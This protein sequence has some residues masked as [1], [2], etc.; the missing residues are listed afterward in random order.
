[1]GLSA[2]LLYR[3]RRLS[4]RGCPNPITLSGEMTRLLTSSTDDWATM[5]GATTLMRALQVRN[6][7]SELVELFLLEFKPL[8]HLT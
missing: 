7:L 6:A 5:R 2:E 4:A 8:P 3:Q 1:M